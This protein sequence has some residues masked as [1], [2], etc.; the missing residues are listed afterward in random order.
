[1]SSKIHSAKTYSSSLNNALFPRFS[2]ILYWEKN[3]YNKFNN[4]YKKLT[5]LKYLSL[6]PMDK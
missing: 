1:M 4:E 6:Q 2:L 5:L 3:L